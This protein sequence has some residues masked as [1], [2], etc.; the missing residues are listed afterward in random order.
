MSDYSVL[1]WSEVG[2]VRNFIFFNF[3]YDTLG[4]KFQFYFFGLLFST[5]NRYWGGNDNWESS[6]YCVLSYGDKIRLVF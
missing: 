4:F 1:Q 3:S 2:V 5:L 6:S